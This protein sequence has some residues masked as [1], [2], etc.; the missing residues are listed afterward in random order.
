MSGYVC[1][2]CEGAN[3]AVFLQTSLTTGATLVSCAEDLP[4]VL[5]GAL[6]VEL[7]VEM[8]VLYPAVQRVVEKAARKAEDAAKG[9]A[10]EQHRPGTRTR[11]ARA[12]VAIHGESGTGEALAPPAAP[13]GK[14]D[15]AGDVDP[16]SE[17]ASADAGAAG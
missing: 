10:T 6:A 16:S 2:F 1:G 13:N 17:G 14:V 15:G 4:V 5:I 7:G 3:P 11:R 8:D 9:P 12:K